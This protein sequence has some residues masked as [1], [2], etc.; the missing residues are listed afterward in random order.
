M[1]ININ[2]RSSRPVCFMENLS[3]SLCVCVC[4]CVSVCVFFFLVLLFSVS[5]F[6]FSFFVF[7]YI[8]SFS[9]FFFFVQ[10]INF[11]S[12]KLD[13]CCAVVCLVRF[14]PYFQRRHLSSFGTLLIFRVT[15][16][17]HFRKI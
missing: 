17:P 5:V 14:S 6:S 13:I 8:F 12:E 2:L 15:F 9:L 11:G 3:L 16:C 4:V 10:Q 7:S 1:K